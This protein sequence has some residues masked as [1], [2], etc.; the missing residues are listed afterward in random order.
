MHKWQHYQ[1]FYMVPMPK[2]GTNKLAI[3]VELL[4]PWSTVLEKLVVS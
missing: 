1:L 2:N 3:T 4:T